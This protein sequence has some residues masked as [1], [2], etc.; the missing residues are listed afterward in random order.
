MVTIVGALSGLLS[1]SKK[2]KINVFSAKYQCE[3]PG[4]VLEAPVPS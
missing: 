1:S 4:P 2:S 3:F